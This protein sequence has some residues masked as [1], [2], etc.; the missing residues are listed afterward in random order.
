MNNYNCL[1][2]IFVDY[3]NY[4]LVINKKCFLYNLI[5]DIL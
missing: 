3:E 1:F 5:L 4:F 2:N